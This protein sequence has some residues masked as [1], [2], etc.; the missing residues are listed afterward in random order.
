MGHFF[1]LFNMLR[2][3]AA[4]ILIGLV[5]RWIGVIQFPIPSGHELIAYGVLFGLFITLILSLGGM[6]LRRMVLPLEDLL[7]AADRV[8]Q[9]DY[10]TRVDERGPR[11]TRSLAKAFNDMASRL[12]QL[13]ERRRDLMADVTHELRT[14]LTVVQGNLEGMLDG[15][16]PSNEAT[17]GSLV[18][19]IKIIS[20]LVDDLRTLALAESGA[21]QL[22]KEPTD[23]AMLVN[24]SFALFQ[25]QAVAKSVTIKLEIPPDLPW[26][27]LDPG[28]IRQVLTNL[29]ANALRYTPA[30]G[31]VSV[32]YRQKDGRALLEVQDSGIGIPPEEL[33]HL[34]ERFHKSSESG[35]MGLGLAIAKQL[36]DAHGGSITA[37]SEPNRGTKMKVELPLKK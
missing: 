29:L 12:D 17:L 30:G 14:P 11:E 35:G 37:E 3:A 36:V 10:S 28:R 5:A 6:S 31:I 21:L 9:G 34:F 2:L 16:Y 8:G 33:A 18:D 15:V 1:F 25:T 19:E 23:L 24:D 7:K 20:R 27:E 26:V 22:R 13:D 32:S 4:V